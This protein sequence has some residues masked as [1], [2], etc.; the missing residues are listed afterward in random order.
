MH[1]LKVNMRRL[2]RKL[3]HPLGYDLVSFPKLSGPYERIH[4]KSSYAPWKNDDAFNELFALISQYSLVDKHRCYELWQLVEQTNA[5]EGVA[6]EIGVWRGGTGALI[7]RRSN[8]PVY[9]ADTFA[10]VVK[11]SDHDPHYEDGEHSDTSPKMVNDLLEKLQIENVT[12]LQGIFPDET[13]HFVEDKMFRFCHIDVD[14][15][16]SA[17]E[18]VDWIWDKMVIGGVILFDDYGTETCA[19][20]CQYVN[21]EKE[22]PDR[23][24]IHNLNG[25]AVWIKIA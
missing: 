5:L 12:L 16:R 1:A 4:V 11:S 2:I 14:T 3:I 21:E 9:L 19:G 8:G 15:Y 18:I 23:M 17:K 25:H 10:G 24:H 20:V 6:I 22:K 13:G 7:A